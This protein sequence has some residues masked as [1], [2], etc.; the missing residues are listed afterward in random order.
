VF[1]VPAFGRLLQDPIKE[2]AQLARIRNYDVVMWGINAPSFSVYY[3]RPTPG[4][5]PHAGDVV[6]TRAKRL[7]EQ[8]MPY[9]SLY[10]SRGVVLARIKQ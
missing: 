8:P 10:A 5:V 9:E 1:V 6:I 3:G 7:A 2:A 4:R